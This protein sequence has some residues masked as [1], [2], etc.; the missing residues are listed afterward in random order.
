[1]NSRSLPSRRSMIRTSVVSLGAIALASRSASAADELVQ[2]AVPEPTPADPWKGLKVGIATYTLREMKAD[3]AIA[4]I[5][6]LGLQYCSIKDTHIP[7]TL[8]TEERKA[9]AGQ[10]RDAG[11][12][13]LSCGNITMK[14]DE[15]DVRRYFEYARDIG[16]NTIVCSPEPD[17]VAI[18]DRM[19]KEFDI[20]LA[21]HN[22]GPEDK[23]FPSPYDVMKLVEKADP[24][25]GLCVD[26]GHSA[27]AGAEPVKAIRE[28]RERVYDV[29]LKDLV[30]IERRSTVCEVGRGVLDIKGMLQ[31][32]LDIKFTGHVGFE[33]E[34]DAKDVMPGL[35][36][37]VGY[38]R[39][40]MAGLTAQA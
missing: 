33:Y 4:A 26:V 37:S 20:R 18:L 35:A 36:E 17:S 28:L 3:A 9:A 8:S 19:V 27:R 30:R 13:P 25:V 39:G 6:R 12:T 34:K 14:N 10:F 2:P 16:V 24:R 7:F 38:C 23:K 22:H 1:M 5:K 31:A 32:L 15:A 40:V 11:V 29:H 21:I